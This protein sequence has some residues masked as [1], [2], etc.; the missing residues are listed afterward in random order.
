MTKADAHRKSRNVFAAMTLGL[1]LVSYGLAAA[2]A[3]FV[4]PLDYWFMWMSVATGGGSVLGFVIAT[5]RH[6]DYIDALVA[7]ID[8]PR[9]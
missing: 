7:A 3:W 6:V 4:Q 1:A 5:A 9:P 8:A 2:M